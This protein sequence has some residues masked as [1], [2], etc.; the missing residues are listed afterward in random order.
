MFTM[1]QYILKDKILVGLIVMCLVLIV[2]CTI[3]SFNDD[4]GREAARY[5][6]GFFTIV[7]AVAIVGSWV[8]YRKYRD[9]DKDRGT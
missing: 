5:A 8:S 7:L 3:M 1:L 2:S 6:A 4:E 9:F